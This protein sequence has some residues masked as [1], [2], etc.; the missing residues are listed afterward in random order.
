MRTAIRI[1]GVVL[2]ILWIGFAIYYAQLDEETALRRVAT[3]AT[4]VV[5]G[6]AFLVYGIKGK[7]PTWRGW[8]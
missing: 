2:G 1:L 8:K 6:A 7:L 5:L 3:C 4:Y